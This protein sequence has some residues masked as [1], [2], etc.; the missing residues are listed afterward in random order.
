MF[1]LQPSEALPFLPSFLPIWSSDQSLRLRY[2]SV[3]WLRDHWLTWAPLPLPHQLDRNIKQTGAVK[4]LQLPRGRNRLRPGQKC[5]VAGWGKVSRWGTYSDTL[6][7]VQLTLQ[8][9]WECECHLRHY[10][11]RTIQLCVGEPTEN[12]AS[13][14]VILSI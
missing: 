12:K 9:D 6:Q 7:E 1:P 8:N 2:H 13:F 4:P 5:I 11:N 10:Y 14:Q 3:S